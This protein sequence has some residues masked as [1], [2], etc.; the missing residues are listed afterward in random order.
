MVAFLW[1]PGLGHFV[2]STIY[3]LDMPDQLLELVSASQRV[4]GWV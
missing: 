3:V 1:R 4:G 2:K